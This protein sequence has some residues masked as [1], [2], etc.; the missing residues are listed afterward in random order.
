MR[1]VHLEVALLAILKTGDMADATRSS[2]SGHSNPRGWSN[3]K[4]SASLSMG[5]D[6]GIRS[7]S[8]SNIDMRIVFIVQAAGQMG[9]LVQEVTNDIV[10]YK[11]V[12][13]GRVEENDKRSKEL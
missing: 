1:A 7:D 12:G 3:S 4:C 13:R 6:S 10:E 8:M 5:A 2:C 11:F 9:F